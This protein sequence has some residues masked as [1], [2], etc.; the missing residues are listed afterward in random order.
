MLALSRVGGCLPPFATSS[1]VQGLGNTASTSPP[2]APSA[3]YNGF[4]SGVQLVRFTAPHK[5][6]VSLDSVKLYTAREYCLTKSS[7]WW[8]KM[9][10]QTQTRD[11]FP[12]SNSKLLGA[13]TPRDKRALPRL[14]FH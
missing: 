13:I 6:P 1:G 11:T 12:G 4:S 7:R 14:P 5:L 10:V 9:M 3:D 2:S 8:F